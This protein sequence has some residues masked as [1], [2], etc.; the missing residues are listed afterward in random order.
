MTNSHIQELLNETRRVHNR[1]RN[2]IQPG[3]TW[4]NAEERYLTRARRE[5]DDRMRM[6]NSNNGN[7]SRIK[8]ENKRVNNLPNAN[9]ISLNNFKNGD[10]AVQYK[11]GKFN[12]Y[13]T[14]NSFRGLLKKHSRLNPTQA[15][16]S[17]PSKFMFVNPLNP[18]N[19][20]KRKDIKFVT[21]YKIKPITEK[22][23]S[24]NKK[25]KLKKKKEQLAKQM[26]E[27]QA[28]MEEMR[29]MIALL[30]NARKNKT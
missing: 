13:M 27:R 11:V 20:V 14:L 30:K 7:N 23:A 24:L 19:R 29:R 15:Y 2:N 8:W 21:L 6:Q 22:S 10:K 5:F 1:I 4:F 16:N 25:E 18:G 12:K 26:A 9:I 17:D 3:E 28:Q